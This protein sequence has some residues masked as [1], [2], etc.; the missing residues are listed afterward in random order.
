M[1]IGYVAKHDSGGNEDENAIS[2]AL[3]QLG[4]SVT[5]LREFRGQMAYRLDCDFVLFHH[6]N[7]PE[8]L[9]RVK[10]PKCFWNFDL[11]T[12]P[13]PTLAERN[14]RRVRWMSDT[15][16]LVDVGFCTDGDWVKENRSGKLVWL[17]QGADERVVG[18]GAS[19]INMP[20]VLFT[21]TYKGGGQGREAFVRHLQ[22]RWQGKCS[23]I[24]GIHGRSLAN[25]IASSQVCV[26]PNH[27]ATDD[28]WS[29]RVYLTAGFGGCLLHPRCKTLESQY[30]NEEEILLFN[31]LDDFDIKLNS[32]LDDPQVCTKFGERAYQRTIKEHLYRHR[33]EKLVQTM[34]ERCGL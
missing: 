13:D 32:L 12:Y 3:E 30:I 15:I 20:P 31:G 5:K 21:G 22:T 6:W 33:I 34:K 26:A 27:P 24:N 29:N 18:K 25:L 10:V 23:V 16:P 2:Y 28:Y 11:V 1:R 17:T 8:S 7:D 4:H 9:S 14:A 19:H